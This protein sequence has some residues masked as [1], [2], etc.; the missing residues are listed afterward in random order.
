[1]ATLHGEE[2][3]ETYAI[4]ANTGTQSV[5]FGRDRYGTIMADLYVDVIDERRTIAV[6]HTQARDIVVRA[7]RPDEPG[8]TLARI[9]K[10]LY[11]T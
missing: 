2:Y 5:V 9:P 10:E 8:T 1:M 4:Y 11:S 7:H 3:A 6:T